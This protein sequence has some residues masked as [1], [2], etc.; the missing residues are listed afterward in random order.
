M[1]VEFKKRQ[2]TENII[3]LIK[4]TCCTTYE[5]FYKKCRRLGEL[6]AGVHFFLD[7][8]GTI[9]V[10]RHEDSVAGWQYEDSDNSLYILAQSNNSKLNSCQRYV[11]PTLIE[12]LKKKYK[13]AKV[14][15]RIE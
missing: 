1:V 4:D 8:N 2:A 3:I 14:I 13:D 12:N 6:D 9:H 11:L 7:A 5:N 15:E 10:A